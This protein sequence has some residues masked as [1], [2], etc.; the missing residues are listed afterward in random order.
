VPP[1]GSS[2]LKTKMAATFM[3]C[4]SY[5]FIWP[6]S[7]AHFMDLCI[8]CKRRDS[9]A[10]YVGKCSSGNVLQIQYCGGNRKQK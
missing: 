1:T 10:P 9:C 5:T 2:N 7:D 4:S 6:S 3:F 8:H